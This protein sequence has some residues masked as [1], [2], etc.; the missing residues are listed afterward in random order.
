MGTLYDQLPRAS[1]E[2]DLSEIDKFFEQVTKLAKKYNMTNNDVIEGFKVLETRRK[3]NLY[4]DNGN[5]HDEQMS[6]MG[7][8]ISNIAH[9]INALVSAIENTD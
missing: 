1:R 6:G 8:E 9:S 7:N 2:N 4:L 5:I 3:N